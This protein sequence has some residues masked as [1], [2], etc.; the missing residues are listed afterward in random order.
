[1]P[2]VS[3]SRRR[4]DVLWQLPNRNPVGGHMRILVTGG[5]GFLGSH[6]VD[7]LLEQGHSV[8][9]LDSFYTGKRDNLQRH[10]SNPRFELI[11]H[12]VV[13][14]FVID[15]ID[16]IYHLASPASPVHYK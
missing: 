16:Q 3:C 12:D 2:D 7:A 14:T 5:A 1:M 10:F 11:R 4:S 9:V 6:L 15:G 8:L 13:E